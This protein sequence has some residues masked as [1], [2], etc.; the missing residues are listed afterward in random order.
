MRSAVFT[1]CLLLF[2][3]KGDPA[4]CLPGD[5]GCGLLETYLIYTNK[6]F[7]ATGNSCSLWTSQDGGNW[8]YKSNAFPG[9][10]GGDIRS[11][12]YAGGVFVAVGSTSAGAGC[13]I[14]T[15]FNGQNWTQASCGSVTGSMF[16]VEAGRDGSTVEFVAAGDAPGP[17][18][19]SVSSTDRGV[20]WTDR[21]YTAAGGAINLNSIAFLPVTKKFIMYQGAPQDTRIRSILGNWTATAVG[22]GLNPAYVAVGPITTSGTTNRVFMAGNAASA[23]YSDDEGAT[24][25]GAI[26]PNIFG[27]TGTSP[28]AVTYGG[29]FVI[30]RGN[31]GVTFSTDGSTADNSGNYSMSN[32]SSDNLVSVKSLGGRYFAGGAGGNIYTSTDGLPSNWF[33]AYQSPVTLPVNSFALRPY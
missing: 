27:A 21:T 25:S 8:S 31:C 18:Y 30:V 24:Y 7:V 32:C 19:Y 22:P 2:A 6:I 26:T 5:T 13:G 3:C 17:N 28:T 20:T 9:C 14:W 23:V 10:S 16:V 12:T 1:L 15:S 33:L 29:I 11:V 4:R